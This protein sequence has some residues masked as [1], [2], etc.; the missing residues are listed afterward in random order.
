MSLCGVAPRSVVTRP[1]LG[2]GQSLADLFG[3]Q[4][5]DGYNPEDPGTWRSW[6]H[7]KDNLL[8]RSTYEQYVSALYW[9]LS[10]VTTVGYGDITPVSAAGKITSMIGMV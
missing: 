7:T 9:A 5:H 3:L 10:T 8:G 2:I 4:D 6:L 1:V